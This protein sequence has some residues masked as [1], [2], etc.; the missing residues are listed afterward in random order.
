MSVGVRRHANAVRLMF[1]G[2]DVTRAIEKS[3][4]SIASIL[5]KNPVNGSDSAV[6]GRKAL[7]IADRHSSP[8]VTVTVD[9][10]A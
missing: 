3:S 7:A 9:D 8:L 1:C 10:F 5:P 6:I 4:V 2:I